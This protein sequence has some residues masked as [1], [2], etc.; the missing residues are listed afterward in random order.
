MKKMLMMCAVAL[1]ATL[2][3]RAQELYCVI[4]LSGGTSAESYPVTYLDAVPSG[5]WSDEYKTT[6]LVLRKISAGTFTMGSPTGELGRDESEVQHQVKLTRDYYIGV[7]QVTQRQWELVMGTRPSYFTNDTCYASRPVESVTYNMIRGLS[8]GK[9]WPNSSAV[10]ATS[11]L[12]VLRAK[13]GLTLD[14]PTEAQWEYACRAGT[15]T[16]LNSEMN[17]TNEYHDAEMNKVGRNNYN[18]GLG[19][20]QECDWSHGTAKAGSY[21]SNAWGLCDMHGNVWEWCLDWNGSYSGDATDPKG[22]SAGSERVMRGGAWGN[23]A[24]YCRSA[25]R[26]CSSPA[27]GSQLRGF[28]LCCPD[29]KP[30]GGP[31]KETV[32]GVEWTFFVTN[33]EACVGTGTGYSAVPETTKGAITVPSVL[34]GRP[35]TGIGNRAFSSCTELTGVTIPEGVASLGH[36]LL[37]LNSKITELTIPA[38]VTNIAEGAF[39]ACFALQAIRVAEG[40]QHYMSPDDV[41]Y[42]KDGTSLVCCP[43]AK[44]SVSVLTSVTNICTEAFGECRELESITLPPK[45]ATLGNL[46]FYSCLKVKELTFPSSVIRLGNNMFPGCRNLDV[47]YFEGLP[48]DNL[49]YQDFLVWQGFGE[50]YH[51]IAIRYNVAHYAEWQVIIE[52]RGLTNAKPYDPDVLP[53]EPGGEIVVPEGE[54][55]AKADLINADSAVKALYLKAPG[56]VETTVDYL[57]CFDAVATSGST[58][59]FALNENGT[60]EVEKATTEVKTAALDVVFSEG[61]TLKIDEPL[62]GFYYSLRQGGDLSVGAKADLNKLGGRD[63]ISFELTKGPFQYFYQTLVTPTP[64]PEEK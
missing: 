54:A 56:G 16:A 47:A 40:N 24:N 11:F 34:G 59:A 61:S 57:G 31:Y 50:P 1:A 9:G 28:R 43:A 35:V 45:L 5:G 41:L 20:L 4:D 7:F 42:T 21:A 38:S 15:T 29:E 63:E 52:E 3:A 12:G 30:E 48:P 32:E 36:T 10:D 19:S 27:I 8:A 6:K 49:Y 17:L 55:E 23:N 60:N 13:S 51:I 53:V 14:L 26:Y 62:V 39:Y 64:V 33:G 37:Y 44:K 18:G 25:K 58:V 2:C 46:V 22:P